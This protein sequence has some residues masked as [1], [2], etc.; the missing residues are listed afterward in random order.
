MLCKSLLA[1]AILSLATTHGVFADRDN[2]DNIDDAAAAAAAAAGEESSSV[3]S[4]SASG[5][6]RPQF[7]VS[8]PTSSFFLLFSSSFILMDQIYPILFCWATG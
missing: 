4:A 5:A 8:Y 3:S 2:V 7:T 6:A 1:A